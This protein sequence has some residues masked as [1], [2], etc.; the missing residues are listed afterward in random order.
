MA[1]LKRSAK[2]FTA[3]HSFDASSGTTTWMPLPP[4]SSGKLLRPSSSSSASRRTTA[5]HLIEIEADVGIEV[6][7]QAVGI[8][9][10]STLLPQ[11]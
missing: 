11:P 5:L 8:P 3:G 6:E 4:D 9:T 2:L 1:R 10:L 7:H